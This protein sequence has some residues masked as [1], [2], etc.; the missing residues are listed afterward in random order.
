MR[1]GDVALMLAGRKLAHLHGRRY[2]SFNRA[3]W[4]TF[5][6]AREDGV[7]AGWTRPRRWLT[8]LRL[9]RHR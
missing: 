4:R 8:V 6:F 1:C 7:T 9:M 3:E 5:L 2:D